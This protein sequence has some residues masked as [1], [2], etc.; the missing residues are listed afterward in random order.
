VELNEVSEAGFLFFGEIHKSRTALP[1][2]DTR[3]QFLFTMAIPDD[4]KGYGIQMKGA[5]C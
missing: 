2:G 1:G 5:V 3:E 4:F